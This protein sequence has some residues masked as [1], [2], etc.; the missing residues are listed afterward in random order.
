VFPGKKHGSPLTHGRTTQRLDDRKF[1][2]HGVDRAKF[3]ARVIAGWDQAGDGPRDE[4]EVRRDDDKPEEAELSLV[5]SDADQCDGEGHLGPVR[6]QRRQDD[7][8]ILESEEHPLVVVCFGADGDD[9]AYEG[10]GD[11]YECLY[12]FK[13]SKRS[14]GGRFPL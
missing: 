6:G 3:G 2:A 14:N 12:P 4:G 1:Q 7:G 5:L 13:V 10:A 11:E 8:R 9:A